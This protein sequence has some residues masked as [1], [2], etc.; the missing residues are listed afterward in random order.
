MKKYYLVTNKI[1]D[2]EQQIDL[3]KIIQFAQDKNNQQIIKMFFW[4][5]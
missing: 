5:F 2:I 1:I 4:E 3:N